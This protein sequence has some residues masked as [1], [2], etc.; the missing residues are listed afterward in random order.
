MA[1]ANNG[2]R[3]DPFRCPGGTAHVW[4]YL[5]ERSQLYAC[6]LCA[7]RISKKELKESTDA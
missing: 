6:T 4:S 7:G 5:G 1:N 2:D 3:T